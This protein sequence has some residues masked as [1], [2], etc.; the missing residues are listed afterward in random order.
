MLRHTDHIRERSVSCQPDTQQ[1]DNFDHDDP[2]MD[3]GFSAFT[4]PIPSGTQP[5]L[6][7]VPTLRRSQR[8]RQ[9]PERYG[10]D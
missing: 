2:L 9:P 3:S 10:T 6:P 5:Q 4:E 7:D 1:T 8:N